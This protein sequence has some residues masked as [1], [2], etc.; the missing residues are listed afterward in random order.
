MTFTNG[1]C[2]VYKS[3][4]GLFISFRR[5]LPYH[6]SISGI[7]ALIYF[8][9]CTFLKN[10][11]SRPCFQPQFLFSGSLSSYVPI[12]LFFSNQD[13]VQEIPMESVHCP[14]DLPTEQRIYHW[15]SFRRQYSQKVVWLTTNAHLL[16]HH[17]CWSHPKGKGRYHAQCQSLPLKSEKFWQIHFQLGLV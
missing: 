7:A 6:T 16:Q 2:L 5:F 17:F 8:N 4:K 14:W 10:I 11:Q 15:N 13:D 3:K 9:P 1:K 12:V